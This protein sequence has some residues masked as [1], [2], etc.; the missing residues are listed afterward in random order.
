M[1]YIYQVGKFSDRLRLNLK[2]FI[3]YRQ[4][5]FNTQCR[6]ETT[7]S[8]SNYDTTQKFSSDYNQVSTHGQSEVSKSRSSDFIKLN[9]NK[10]AIHQLT[11]GDTSYNFNYRKYL[12]IISNR[13]EKKH[14]NNKNSRASY[15]DEKR[16]LILFGFVGASKINS[17]DADD[18]SHANESNEKIETDKEKKD[19]MTHTDKLISRGVLLMLDLDHAKANDLFHEALKSAQKDE[20]EEKELLILTLLAT[21]YFESEQFDKA[22]QLFIALMKRLISKNTEVDSPALL[23]LSLKLAAIYSRRPETHK[24]ADIGFKFVIDTLSKKLSDILYRLDQLKDDQLDDEKKNLLAL[25]GWGYDWYAKHLLTINNFQDAIY[26]LKRAYEISLHVLG[27]LHDQTLILL[28]DIG[29]TIAMSRSPT[30]GR[31][32]IQRAVDG[33]I[34]SNSKELASFYLNLGLTTVRS[35]QPKEGRK[36][37]ERSLEMALK[38]TYDVNS[39]EI[40]NLSKQCLKE[41]DE[42]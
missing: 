2:T 34:Q 11:S 37:C 6:R 1:S 5:A 32:Y 16:F 38:N 29:T 17:D 3:I 31:E 21:N 13:H 26:Y 18:R 36:Y 14:K 10:P 12:A 27:P 20:N 8:N 25:L 9:V 41:C 28:N 33:A 24:K 39:K 19:V 22:E 23:E 30:E 4:K 42:N 7:E 40:V 35:Q 15:I